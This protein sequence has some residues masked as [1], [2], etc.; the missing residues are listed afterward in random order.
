MKKFDVSAQTRSYTDTV[1]VSAEVVAENEEESKA[2]FKKEL[3]HS[4][5]LHDFLTARESPDVVT[6][7]TPV[8]KRIDHHYLNY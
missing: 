1:I 5:K 6:K 4:G 3:F 2:I 7:E 8:F